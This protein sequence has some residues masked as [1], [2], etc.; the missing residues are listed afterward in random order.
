MQSPHLEHT[1]PRHRAASGGQRKVTGHLREALPKG[2]LEMPQLPLSKRPLW[3]PGLR[4]LPA[5]PCQAPKPSRA[6]QKHFSKHL[7]SVRRERVHPPL[8]QA[9]AHPDTLLQGPRVTLWCTK[10]LRAH[11]DPG[12]CP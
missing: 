12:M 1:T 6:K 10:L 4:A 3:S 2:G 8:P 5:C 9:L 7:Q 11:P